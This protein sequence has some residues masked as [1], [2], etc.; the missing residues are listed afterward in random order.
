MNRDDGRKFEA[1]TQT[2]P[3]HFIKELDTSIW[4]LTCDDKT[5]KF[6]MRSL[7]KQAYDAGYEDSFG[8]GVD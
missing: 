5:I 7:L 6:T 2:L 8:Y 1:F 4:I 3:E